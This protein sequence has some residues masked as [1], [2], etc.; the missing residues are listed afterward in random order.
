MVNWSDR[1]ADLP[2]PNQEHAETILRLASTR[3]MYQPPP[4]LN[5]LRQKFPFGA[6]DGGPDAELTSREAIVFSGWALDDSGR[7]SVI[8]R[9]ESAAAD[10]AADKS[11]VGLVYVGK[12]IFKDGSIPQGER[13]FYGF[14]GIDKMVWEFRLEPGELKPESSLG[15]VRLRFFAR[16]RIGQETWIGTR[17]IRFAE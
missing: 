7:L 3:H 15:K 10:S 11:S 8:V 1:R 9:R 12:A 13:S 2:Y 17:T 6:L 14:P 4:A 5:I 16:D